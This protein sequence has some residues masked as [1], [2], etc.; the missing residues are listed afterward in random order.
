MQICIVSS[1][2]LKA[3][4]FFFIIEEDEESKRVLEL[5]GLLIEFVVCYN[6]R[7]RQEEL[8]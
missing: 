5:L 1:F 2:K 4:L 7:A 3:K 6:F 8:V